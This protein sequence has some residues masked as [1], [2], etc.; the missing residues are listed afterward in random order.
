MSAPSNTLYSY[1]AHPGEKWTYLWVTTLG[2]H[3]LSFRELNAM[4]LSGLTFQ[5]FLFMK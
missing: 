5:S 3:I 4:I 2:R 1:L